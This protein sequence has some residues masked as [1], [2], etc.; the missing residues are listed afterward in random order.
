MPRQNH[1]ERLVRGALQCMREKGYAR[2]TARDIAAAANSNL[3]SI[4]YHFGSKEA[5]LNEAIR[6]GFAE[7]TA[8][9]GQVAFAEGGATPLDRGRASLVALIGTFKDQRSLMVAFVEALA[10]AERSDDL[11]RQLAAIYEESRVAV[12][13]MV[14]ASFDEATIAAADA[15]AV[16]SFLIAICDGLMLQWL[17]DPDHL[18]SAEELI[19]SLE[20]VVMEIA[21]APAPAI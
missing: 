16:A 12:G 6:E 3:G 8:Q 7:W 1:R 9:V 20:T 13:Q 21:R 15:R 10:Q 19:A 11:R 17:I 18:P 2:T 14:A 5:L 4:G